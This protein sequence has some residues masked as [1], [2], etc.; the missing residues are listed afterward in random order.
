VAEAIEAVLADAG[1]AQTM[2]PAARRWA[3]DRF[4]WPLVIDRV[5]TEM[6][7]P[8]PPGQAVLF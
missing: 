1:G 2:G 7:V 6:G 3:E 5:L 8:I 4:T